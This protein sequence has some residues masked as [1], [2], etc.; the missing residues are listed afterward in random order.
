MVVF[1]S[2]ACLPESSDR[3]G[4]KGFLWK[5]NGLYKVGATK[6]GSNGEELP[7]DPP[8]WIA[9]LFTLP[10]LVRDEYSH[11][12]RLLIAWNDLDQAPHEEAIPFE[13]LAGEGAE[14]AR[15]LG[16]GGLMLPPDAGTRKL[17]LSYL[18]SAVTKVASRVRMVEALG[19]VEG[20][21][22]LP[23]GDVV[24]NPDE[25]VRFSG[26]VANTRTRATKGTLEGWKDGVACYA[27][28]NTR[29]AFAIA[30]AFA[31]PLLDLV[32]PDGGGGF[33]L[34]GASSRGKTTVLECAAS[35]WERPDPLTTWRATGN[36]LEGIAAARNDG[37]LALDE[38]SQVDPK[39]AGS[40]AY[41]LANGSAKARAT[42]EGAARSMR[43]WRLIFLSSGEQGLEDKML[44]AGGRTRAGQE[45]RV[46]DIPCPPDGM[47]INAHGFPSFGVLAET[48]KAN[49]RK[50]FGHAARAFIEQQCKDWSRREQIL[51]QLRDMESSW[52]AV[53]VPPNADAQVRRVAGRFALVAVAG[54]LA[55]SMG[56]LP[57]PVGEAF[58]AAKACFLAWLESRGS[59]GASE[60]YRGIE[61]VLDFLDRHGSARFDVWGDRDAKI[62]NRAGTRK[63]AEGVDGWDF[64]LTPEG[65]KEACK[66]FNS[67]AMA[68]ICADAGILD[69]MGKN[70]S[71]SLAIPGHGKVRVYVIRASSVS[72]YLG[73]LTG[74]E[75]EGA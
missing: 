17:F 19:W 35:V 12:W 50:N 29:L 23:S 31:G 4:V 34:L 5:P 49:A 46:P 51:G 67:S 52:L 8:K 36:G 2:S 45:V 26:G 54:E 33:N 37:F 75:I 56:I 72:K 25:P 6:T 62:I 59:S 11:G 43:Q 10:G 14:L 58:E 22:V 32:R 41:L 18:C 57:W 73:H 53:A 7:P 28:G 60:V 44:E 69:S 30:S 21:F 68:K 47:F 1:R 38:L 74:P 20:A 24:G 39:E 15:T 48:L 66:G 3:P 64:F 70:P 55:Q 71:R 42:K 13:L 27:V 9:P 63:K 40:V 65:W 61:A 16:Q